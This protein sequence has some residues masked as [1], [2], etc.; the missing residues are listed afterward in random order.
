MSTAPERAGYG[1]SALPWGQVARLK[2][3]L[4]FLMGMENLPRIVDNLVGHGMDPATP[5]AVVRY[6]T[7]PM[8]R[9]SL[10]HI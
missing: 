10:I 4:V 7:W 8:Q 1:T 2:G 9:L 5:A 3:T 6:G